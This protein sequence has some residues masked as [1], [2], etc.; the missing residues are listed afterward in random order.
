MIRL[1]NKLFGRKE[2]QIESAALYRDPIEDLASIPIR[3]TPHEEVIIS[4]LERVKKEVATRG[5]GDVFTIP[6]PHLSTLHV[7][8]I[9]LIGPIMMRAEEYG[10]HMLLCTEQEFTFKVA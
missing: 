10:A 2:R 3:N 6:F 4:F 9:E 1:F 8:P 5:S 7:N